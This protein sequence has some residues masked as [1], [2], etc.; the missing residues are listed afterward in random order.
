MNLYHDN[1]AL[2]NEQGLCFDA[3]KLSWICGTPK[4]SLIP[5]SLE[6]ALPWL[7]KKTPVRP[8]VAIIG[9]R[10]ASASQLEMAEQVGFDIGLLGLHVI[11]GG[12][13]GVME[14]TCRGVA[15][16]GG[17]SIGLLPEAE[18]DNANPYVTVPV[19]TGIGIA[20]N[21]LISRAALCVIAVGG[22][23]GTLSEI[24]LSLQFGKKVYTLCEAPQVEGALAF[25]SWQDLKPVMCKHVL[26]LD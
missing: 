12:R 18:W 26:R 15:R 21:A 13:Q 2:F 11:C 7:Q 4:A 10:E 14:A 22:G 17:I 8:P 23:L 24:A 6:D 20:R 5:I 19:A 1:F 16:A 3:T 25:E 9:P